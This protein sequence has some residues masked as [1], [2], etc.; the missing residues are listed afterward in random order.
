MS[1]VYF[2]ADA[3]GRQNPAEALAAAVHTQLGELLSVLE[4]EK[5]RTLVQLF[6]AVSAATTD[7]QINA[8]DWQNPQIKNLQLVPAKVIVDDQ[9]DQI[10]FYTDA[11]RVTYSVTSGEDTITI[12]IAFQMTRDEC[13][14][15]KN[16]SDSQK[17]R[18]LKT[19]ATQAWSE[20]P[21]FG[22]AVANKPAITVAPVLK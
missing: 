7:R 6:Q 17:E 18:A 3:R 22:G 2:L 5:S 1:R 12:T 13:E 8:I 15:V 11:L 14:I 4:A 19:F 21:V 9:N 20:R 16:L 10:C